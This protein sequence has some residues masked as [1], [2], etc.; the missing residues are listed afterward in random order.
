[1]SIEPLRQLGKYELQQRLGQGGMAEVWK[2][3]DTQL[4]RN[5]AIKLL[6]ANLQADPNFMTRFLHEAQIIASLRHPNIVQIHDF[7]V[8][9]PSESDNPI[10]YMVMTYIEGQTLAGYI[11]QTSAKGNIPTP[12]EIV[13]LFTSI[14]LAVDYAH[15][16]GMIHRDIKPANILLDKNN[17]ARNPM[18]EPIL[19]DFGLARLLGVTAGSLT[20]SQPGTPLYASP[21]QAR[22][23][24]GNERSDIYSLGVILYEI[25]TGVPPFRGESPMAILAQH[26]NA[27]P[28]PP[29]QINPNIPPA[30]SMV[31]LTAL[32]KD[33][34]ARF[35]RATTMTA[36]IAES[37][38]IRPPEI[39]G[40]PSYPPSLSSMPTHINPV[41]TGS[42]VVP[43]ATPSFA[44]SSSSPV[45]GSNPSLPPGAGT[46]VLG[47]SAP[48]T[49]LL[50]QSTIEANRIGGS[51]STGTIQS[52]PAPPTPPPLPTST[53]PPRNRRRWLYAGISILLLLVLLGASLGAYFVFFN[54]PTQPQPAAVPGGQAFFLSTGQFNQG[55]AQGIADELVIRLQHIPNPQQ[56]NSYYAWLIGDR[57]P[58]AEKE[59][60]QPPPQFTLPLLIG[61]LPVVQGNINFFYPGTAHH[62]NLFSLTS[63]M[64]ITEESSNGTPKG[65]AADRS[66]W[67]YYA[68]LPQT[69]YGNPPLSALDHIRHLFYKE[70]KVGVLGLPG[71][72]D[73]WLFRNTE[74]VLEWAISARDDYHPQVSDPTVIHNLFVSILDYL[75]GSPNVHLDVPGG[76][77]AADPVI[78]RVGLLSVSPT[79]QL[80]EDLA[81][82]PP[83]YLDHMELH[84]QGV[85]GAPDATSQMRSLAVKIVQSLD[86]V[87]LWL[88]QVRNFARQ[89]VLMDAT[90]L[91]QPSTLT[92]L[93]NMLTFATYAYIGK[94]NPQTDQVIP[95]VLQ[96]HYNIQLLATLSFTSTLPQSI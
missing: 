54:H 31:V 61:K 5:V 84:L 18:G 15:Q 35:A 96:A 58:Q 50:W 17:T 9:R 62:D 4:Q 23:Y 16:K 11:A 20:A 80:K 2:A 32:A 34:N 19:S 93:D 33:P 37:L 39:L 65:P 78:S 6:H 47:Q 63:R 73:V 13:N 25:L 21:E 64:L 70:T 66:T 38:N 60:F 7:Q 12:T 68:E 10:A 24:A 56:G 26:L 3:Y 27:E 42:P 22:G 71:G 92:M 77:V 30:L 52:P 48:Q 85:V 94:L 88:N 40:Q 55:T 1:M 51:S 82:N 69:A 41:Q 14:S 59:P 46:P 28:T 79:Q 45:V 43:S 89:L 72:L 67:R 8:Y 44:S 81:N 87:R 90:Q 91:A 75:D 36:A 86:N 83:G 74:K 76:T 49:P 53:P 95:G 29:I 57:H